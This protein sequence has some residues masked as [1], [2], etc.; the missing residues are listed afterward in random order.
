MPKD[1]IVTVKRVLT[2]HATVRVRAG[3]SS[4]AY[5]AA[6]DLAERGAVA[7]ANGDE[8][9]TAEDVEEI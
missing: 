9:I 3:D 2:E 1:Y 7:W 6:V 5:N 4:D 8:S